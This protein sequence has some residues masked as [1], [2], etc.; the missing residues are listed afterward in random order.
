MQSREAMKSNCDQMLDISVCC[1]LGGME[2]VTSAHIPVCLCTY[3]LSGD[4]PQLI[5]NPKQ[6]DTYMVAQVGAL[7]C[8]RRGK[9]SKLKQWPSQTKPSVV[10]LEI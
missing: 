1:T 5:V 4:T 3:Q 10:G 6:L 8:V 2:D 9:Q 7:H